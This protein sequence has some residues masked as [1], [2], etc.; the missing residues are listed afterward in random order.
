MRH[1]RDANELLEVASNEL[2]AIVGDDSRLRF[3]VLLLGSLQNHFDVSFL[4]GLPHAL[5]ARHAARI[6]AVC[7]I[8]P[9][10]IESRAKTLHL[11]EEAGFS[12]SA[13][14]V[15]SWVV[16]N[17][18]GTATSSLHKEHIELELFCAVASGAPSC[19]FRIR[20][21]SEPFAVRTALPT[22]LTHYDPGAPR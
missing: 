1:A 11:V 16:S 4:H 17:A 22:L 2:R 7:K 10:V 6:P 15:T 3:R 8:L 5:K 13:F 19:A 14:K 20:H 12:D 18:A 9:A 21:I